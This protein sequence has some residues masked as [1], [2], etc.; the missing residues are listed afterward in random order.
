MEQHLLLKELQ[1][2]YGFPDEEFPRLLAFFKEKHFK[3]NEIMFK[4]GDVVKHT[5]FILK[6]CTRQYYL[7]PEG[8]E[9]IIYFAEEGSF[10]G[11]LNSFL[12]ET[13]TNL[14]LQSLE[15]TDVI[16][17]DLKNWETAMTTIPAL[18]LYHI[19]NHQRLMVK[20]K[21]EMGRAH[22]ETP[23]EKYRRLVNEKPHL[24]QRLPQYHIAAYLG[25]TPETLSRIRKRNTLI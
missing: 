16:Y 17:L 11:E 9:R 8:A 13:P 12:H 7:S 4:A 15:E 1:S 18:T 23:D 14:N 25:V 22:I 24:L 6:G 19:K 10:C 3:K 21:E 20:L 2:K 5:Y